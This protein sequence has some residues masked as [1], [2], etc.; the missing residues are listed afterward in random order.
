MRAAPLDKGAVASS[1]GDR[2]IL[3]IEIDGVAEEHDLDRRH[4]SNQGN[5]HAVSHQPQCFN[6][7]DG[8]YA[9]EAPFRRPPRDAELH[10]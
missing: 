4:Q 5:S 9:S 6:S 10:V 3:R 2:D 1:N 7:G 8:H